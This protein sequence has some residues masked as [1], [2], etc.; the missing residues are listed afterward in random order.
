MIVAKAFQISDI[1]GTTNGYLITFTTDN[2]Q[3]LTCT[4]SAGTDLSNLS[5]DGLTISKGLEFFSAIIPVDKLPK[6]NDLK[7]QLVCKSTTKQCSYSG[8]IKLGW[9]IVQEQLVEIAVSAEAKTASVGLVSLTAV[10]LA[11]SNP[12]LF[13]IG[14]LWFYRRRK[15]NRFGLVYDSATK[16]VIPFAVVRLLD[17][18]TNKVVA[19]IVTDLQGR[20]HLLAGEGSYTLEASQDKY[21]TY[22][23]PITLSGKE[24]EITTNIGLSRDNITP[25][26]KLQLRRWAYKLNKYIFTFGFIFSILMLIISFSVINLIIVAIYIIQLMFLMLNRPP[27]DWGKIIEVGTGKGLKGAFISI[28][29]TSE[30][31]QVDMQLSDAQGRFGLIL[32]KQPYLLKVDLS[33]YKPKKI[34]KNWDKI[35]LPGGA[36]A[37]K[38]P[39]GD[40]SSLDIEMEHL[41][42]DAK[43]VSNFGAS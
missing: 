2:N 9:S 35:E 19:Q 42:T 25:N 11:A 1:G 5:T 4:I 41:I 34:N 30:Q 36:I 3:L 37:Y 16:Q 23:M 18:V 20:Y 14:L 43:S 39:Q 38:M 15:H 26:K 13:W 31:R 22:K 17:T 12:Q 33:G 40:A 24:L 32:E 8:D 21:S 10:T 6:T 27:R 28:L 7:Y 29:D